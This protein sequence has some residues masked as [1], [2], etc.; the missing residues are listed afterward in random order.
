MQNRISK[1]IFNSINDGVFTVDKNCRITSFNKSAEKITG[2][3]AAEAVGKHCFDIFRTE[4]CNKRCALKDTLKTEEQIKN[5]RVTIIT[6]EGC[7]M[8]INV[9]TM[10]LRDEDNEV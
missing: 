6:R 2:F 9:T 3:S 1:I 5:V 4:I 10:L 7:E 8:P